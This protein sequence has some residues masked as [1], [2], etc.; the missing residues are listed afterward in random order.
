MSRHA[1]YRFGSKAPDDAITF[2][3][4]VDGEFLAETFNGTWSTETTLQW[5]DEVDR[6]FKIYEKQVEIFRIND[7]CNSTFSSKSV[8][9]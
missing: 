3:E 7:C 4:F 8:S 1:L 5:D 6:Y 9:F 2:D